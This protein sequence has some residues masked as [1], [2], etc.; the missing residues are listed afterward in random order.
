MRGNRWG[1]VPKSESLNPT[2]PAST[3]GPTSV[4]PV[5]GRTVPNKATSTSASVMTLS[6]LAANISGLTTGAATS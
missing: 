3:S 1:S 6:R 5:P 2:A 4:P